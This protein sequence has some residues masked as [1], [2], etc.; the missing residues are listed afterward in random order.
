MENHLEIQGDQLETKLVQI[1]REE[2]YKAKKA[3]RDNGLKLILPISL[4]KR[5]F[6]RPF[7]P[8]L[9]DEASNV[10]KVSAYLQ[11]GQFQSALVLKGKNI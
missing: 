2:G 11:L 10:Y 6:N 3:G 5:A 4:F 1:S 8:N 7:Y 9:V